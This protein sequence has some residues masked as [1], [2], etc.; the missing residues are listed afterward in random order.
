MS[1]DAEL[2]SIADK[3]TAREILC[4]PMVPVISHYKDDLSLD[5]PALESSIEYLIE[6]G[7]RTGKGALLIGGAGADFPMLTLEERKQVARTS[8]KAAAGRVPIVLGAQATDERVIMGLAELAE[9][10]GIYAL[11]MGP[12]YYFGPS[13]EDVIRLFSKVNASLKRSG[14]MVYNTWW[15]GYNMPLKVVDQLTDL[16]RVVSLK[17]S[18][19]D[20]AVSYMQGVARYAEKVAVIDNNNTWPLTSLLGGT[21][22]ITHLTSVWPEHDLELFALTSAGEY[23]K[24]MDLMRA[25]DWPFIGFR[26]KMAGRTSGEGSV[27]RATLEICGRVGGPSRPPARDLT[28]DEREELRSILTEIGAPVAQNTPALR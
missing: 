3:K 25:V 28:A 9:E 22:F 4:G 5:L 12:P 11:Q 10:L 23:K 27:V 18:V 26:E 2:P 20:G 19:P 21:G 16:D 17:W 15:T 1:R 8:V 6:H 7:V 24:T 13:D 14:I